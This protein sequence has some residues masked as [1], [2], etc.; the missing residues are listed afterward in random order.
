MKKLFATPK[1][2]II[3]TLC[4]IAIVIIAAV[5]ILNAVHIGRN[6]AE[7]FALKDAG[8]NKNDVS[9][10]RSELD[11]DDGRFQYEVDFYSNGTEYEY[12]LLAR[13]GEIISRDTDGEKPAAMASSAQNYTAHT[14]DKPADIE[15]PTAEVKTESNAAADVPPEVQ[16][17]QPGNTADAEIISL[18]KAKAAA[19]ADAGLTETEVTFT[20]AKTDRDDYVT[21]YDIEF[22]TDSAEYDYEINAADGDVREKSIEPFRIQPS[23]SESSS[24]AVSDRYIGV[25]RAKEIAVAHAGLVLADVRFSKA[26]LEND[27]GRT[28]YEIEFYHGSTEYE[29][30]I[31]AVSGDILEFDSERE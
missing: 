29:Y 7:L 13:N 21:V 26:K 19:L 15:S 3:S 27:D 8:L 25:D 1:R 2:A 18:E 24:A 22:Y 12:V 31:D 23:A 17:A 11:F 28:E 16:P 6:E 4:L 14:D 10:L 30:S 20:K 5:V 9:G